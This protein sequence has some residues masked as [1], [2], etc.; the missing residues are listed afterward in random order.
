M[1]GAISVLI[2]GLYADNIFMLL[3]FF[4]VPLQLLFLLLICSSIFGIGALWRILLTTLEVV[5]EFLFFSGVGRLPGKNDHSILVRIR[6]T[7]GIRAFFNGISTAAR[8]M[9]TLS[10]LWDQQLSWRTFATSECFQY[11]RRRRRRIGFTSAG[12]CLYAR[13]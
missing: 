2:Y 12:R 9:G 4:L 10:I 5:D 8:D 11:C 13:I 7:I 1:T 6:V 3:F